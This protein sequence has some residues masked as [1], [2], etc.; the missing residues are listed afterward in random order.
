M[1]WLYHDHRKFESLVYQCR[2]ASDAGDWEIVKGL[3]EQLLVAYESHVAIEEQIL[4]PAYEAHP[5]APA[6]PTEA[7]KSDHV[8]IFRLFRH[9]AKQL[10]DDIP[11]SVADDLAMLF[12]TLARHHEKEEQIFLPMA[13][14]ALYADKDAILADLE[15]RFGA[16][17]A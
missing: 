10:E 13:S 14:E 16:S 8:Q 4:F 5:G 17:S 2:T 1:N 12:R 6:E 7:L 3:V 15:T 9:V 11:A